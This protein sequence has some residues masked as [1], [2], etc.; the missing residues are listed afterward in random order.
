VIFAIETEAQIIQ[1]IAKNSINIFIISYSLQLRLNRQ[2]TQK[3]TG[4]PLPESGM[5]LNVKDFLFSIV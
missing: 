1:K 2:Y 3:A 5:G 4:K